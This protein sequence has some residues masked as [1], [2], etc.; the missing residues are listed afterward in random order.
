LAVSEDEEIEE[1]P[2]L[3]PRCESPDF[4]REK[5]LPLFA[6]L[7]VATFGAGVAV[8]RLELAFFVGVVMLLAF[9]ITPAYKCLQCGKR[10][11]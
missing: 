6:I 9:L 10:F 4:V 2:K 1:E 7:A 3:C 8:E 5:W 11:E